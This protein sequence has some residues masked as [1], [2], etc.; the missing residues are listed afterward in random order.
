VLL[1]GL[2]DSAELCGSS[3]PFA[4]MA[5][6]LSDSAKLSGSSWPFATMATSWKLEMSSSS[7]KVFGLL[8][9]LRTHQERLPPSLAHGAPRGSFATRRLGL[10][11]QQA[12]LHVALQVLQVAETPAQLPRLSLTAAAPQRLSQAAPAARLQQN[13]RF[14]RQPRRGQGPATWAPPPTAAEEPP[15]RVPESLLWGCRPRCFH[16]PQRS[17]VQAVSWPCPSHLCFGRAPAWNPRPQVPQDRTAP[18]PSSSPEEVAKPIW[19]PCH[20]L[21]ASRSRCVHHC[22]VVPT[23]QSPLLQ[24]PARCKPC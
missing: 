24:V 9:G 17:Q 12:P 7:L 13:R 16:Q 20:H 2:S 21:L 10:G 15:R 5:T 18:D 23:K 8:E 14:S 3:W 1:Q 22:I 6:F 19:R 4:K 11:A